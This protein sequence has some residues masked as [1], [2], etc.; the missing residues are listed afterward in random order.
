MKI[1]YLRGKTYVLYLKGKKYLVNPYLD[2]DITPLPIS[3]KDI[4]KNLDG[5][6]YT[7]EKPVTI[8]NIM[9]RYQSNRFKSYLMNEIN[10]EE[11]ISGLR[12]F[13]NLN[14]KLTNGEVLLYEKL[15]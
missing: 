7:S 4:F 8:D 11:I 6:I 12:F 13:E 1:H 9:K 2:E 14:R 15:S 5:I 10:D 3:P